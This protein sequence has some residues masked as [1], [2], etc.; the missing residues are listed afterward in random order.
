M[1]V[2][3][4]ETAQR[5]NIFH[6]RCTIKGK[7][8]D[9]I[10]DGGSFTN[11]ASSYMVDKLGL[12]RTKHHR[13]YKL[14]WLDDKVELKIHDQVIVPFSVGRYQDQVVCDV[15]PIQACHVFLD[16]PW[17]FD[18]KTTHIG[19]TNLCTFMHH[20][21]KFT[22]AP[23]SPS[24]VHELQIYNEKATCT[25]NNFLIKPSQ[26]KRSITARYMV[27][28]IFFKDVLSTYFGGLELP[29]KVTKLLPNFYNNL[30]MC[31]PKRYQMFC[32]FSEV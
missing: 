8:C 22:L 4:E 5:E 26:V 19:L 14:M 31:F 23:L 7:V 17:Q 6:P 11:V 18:K 1:M 32:L 27:L 9:L 20:K 28:L 16:R 15:V 30:S 13:P 10:I 3:P 21:C 29:Q 24:Q 12:E 25:K 2:Q